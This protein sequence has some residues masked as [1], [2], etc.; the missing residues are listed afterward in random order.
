MQL[1]S[2]VV[3]LY[4][5]KTAQRWI[6]WSG[7]RRS[8]RHPSAVTC[9]EGKSYNCKRKCSG[10]KT[11]ELSLACPFSGRMLGGGQFNKDWF[12]KRNGFDSLKYQN[13]YHQL[14]PQRQYQRIT[15]QILV[16]R[17]EQKSS[18]CLE[19][20]ISKDKEVPM[21]TLWKQRS[22]LMW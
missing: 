16:T 1:Q 8:G 14:D 10:R 12:T 13:G 19:I 5:T 20:R 11:C 15:T 7:L 21:H 9:R 3:A 4:T 6:I 17:T 18:I 2:H 22:K